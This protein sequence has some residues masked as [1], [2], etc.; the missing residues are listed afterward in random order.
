MDG[1]GLSG[2]SPR[3]SGCYESSENLENGNYF[4]AYSSP[5]G[6]LNL[7]DRST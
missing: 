3:D 7:L 5:K 4:Y 6:L 1:Q 2:C